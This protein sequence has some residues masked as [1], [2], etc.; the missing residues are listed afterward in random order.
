MLPSTPGRGGVGTAAATR[1][2]W[3][4]WVLVTWLLLYLWI[5]I[6]NVTG[7]IPVEESTKDTFASDLYWAQ[8]EPYRSYP[9]LPKG[10]HLAQRSNVAYG[11]VSMTVSFFL[12][13]T[14]CRDASPIISYGLRDAD[15]STAATLV[16]L[17]ASST[18]PP[19]QYQYTGDK[20]DNVTVPSDWIYHIELADL[21]A[22]NQEYWYKIKILPQN[23]LHSEERD[24]TDPIELQHDSNRRRSTLRG[25]QR[26]EDHVGESPVHH[27][28]TP[29]LTGAPTAIAFVGD[30][31]RS[32]NSVRTMAAM[33]KA[34]HA[35]DEIPVSH[36]II[37]GDISYANGYPERWPAWFETAEP[38]FR[39]TPVAVAAGNHEVECDMNTLDVFVPYEHW[40]YNPNRIQEAQIS[41]ITP[42]YLASSALGGY[43]IS[44][45]HFQADYQYGN[46]FYA[47]KHGLLHM[48]VL[49]SYADCTPGSIQYEWLV[50][51]LETNIDRK[52][53]PWLIVVLHAPLYTTFLSHPQR[54]SEA[55]AAAIEPLLAT[56]GVNLVLAGH[57]HA[58]MRTH[59]VLNYTAC[60][61][62]KNDAA[63]TA[64]AAAPVHITVGTGGCYEGPPGAGY[65][66][67][68]F[69][70][71]WVA[72]RRLR[73]SGYGHLTAVNATHAL[74]EFR[75]NAI[76]DDFDTDLSPFLRKLLH[77]IQGRDTGGGG[78]TTEETAFRDRV[79]LYNPHAS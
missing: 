1:C 39:S 36:V 38:L 76:T 8:Q 4:G 49:N 73:D 46:S 27:F 37:G 17:N 61:A 16:F 31:G 45:I 28:R 62:S 72:V 68:L 44:P 70:E 69:A 52:L 42:E 5:H 6:I 74:W 30:L 11:I 21:Q 77:F 63:N 51:E 3:C 13:F 58:Y 29:P 33:F 43:C 60:T 10:I 2:S 25:V 54:A 15:P 18:S 26:T 32:E 64:N 57:D 79:W 14:E 19:L 12:D 47:V 20:S 71:D 59:P 22:G 23:P 35:V 56:Y 67:K 41:P 65:N 48:V 40:F 53:T 55:S 50:T 9:C 75:A 7:R 24:I 34:A 66:H 78:D